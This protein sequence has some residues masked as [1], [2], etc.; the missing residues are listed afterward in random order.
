MKLS[1]N[2]IDKPSPVWF[3]K[4]KRA[5]SLTVTFGCALLLALGYTDQSLALIIIKLSESFLMNMLD[6]FGGEDV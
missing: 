2:N 4:L 5:V 3:S 1:V 6:I